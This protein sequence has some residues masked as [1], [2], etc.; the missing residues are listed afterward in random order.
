MDKKFTFMLLMTAANF[1]LAGAVVFGAFDGEEEGDEET[2]PVPEMCMEEEG[3]E[4]DDEETPAQT[5]EEGEEG[6]E[7]E[8]VRRY[9]I[10]ARNRMVPNC[11]Y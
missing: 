11:F 4:G 1:L 2:D 9:Q 7:G 6:D 8:M 10:I 3:E 5:S